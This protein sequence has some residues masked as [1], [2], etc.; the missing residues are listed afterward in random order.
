MIYYKHRKRNLQYDME[1]ER[2]ISDTV[3][4]GRSYGSRRVTTMLQ[5]HGLTI[6]GNRVRRHI[7]HLNL[8]HTRGKGYR[9]KVPRMLVVS[10][11]NLTWEKD[12]TRVYIDNEMWI[13]F[14]TYVD[15]CSRK[16]KGYL[17]SR[18]S[19]TRG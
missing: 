13:Y 12:I 4:E 5:R 14:T 9:K 2:R 6:G 16:T 7:R 8:I 1:L 11:S 15:L 18:M 17:V 19:R 3:S 10:K